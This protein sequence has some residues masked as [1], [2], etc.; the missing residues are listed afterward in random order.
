MQIDRFEFPAWGR[1][2]SYKDRLSDITG[3]FQKKEEILLIVRDNW[4]QKSYFRKMKAELSSR[5]IHFHQ[6]SVALTKHT[7]SLLVL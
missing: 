7:E 5:T 3:S 6:A 1:L 2:N 4:L